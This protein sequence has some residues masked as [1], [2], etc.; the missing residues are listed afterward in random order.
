M[1]PEALADLVRTSV[2]QLLADR[3]LD[4]TAAPRQVTV[5]RPRNPEHGDY[6]TNIALQLAKKVGVAP[7]DLATWLVEALQA[8]PAIAKASASG[9]AQTLASRFGAGL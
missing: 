1:T 8:Q 2:A 4:T 6:A 3:G 5:E 9:L 7:R